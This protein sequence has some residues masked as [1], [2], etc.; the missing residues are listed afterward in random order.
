MLTELP[1]GTW[2]DLRMINS[3]RPLDRSKYAEEGTPYVN[4][5]VGEALCFTTLE[6]ETFQAAK[7]YAAVLSR[8][9]NDACQKRND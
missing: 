1:N 9:V 3:V 7:D 5:G 4:V 2:L 8:M 6:F